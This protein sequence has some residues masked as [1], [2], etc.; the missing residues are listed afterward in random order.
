MTSKYSFH[1]SIPSAAIP[2]ERIAPA[3]P[4]AGSPAEQITVPLGQALVSGLGAAALVATVSWCFVTPDWREFGPFVLASGVGVFSA[5]WGVLMSD[6]RGLLRVS[7]NWRETTPATAPRPQDRLILVKGG[8]RGAPPDVEIPPADPQAGPAF[9]EPFMLQ[10]L[11]STALADLERRWPRPAVQS[12]RDALIAAGLAR[13]L[14]KG[15]RAGWELTERGRAVAARCRTSP[16]A[17]RE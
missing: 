2:G 11:T 5:V 12:A 3:S 6:S 13:W 1:E 7:E 17:V 14:G 4:T 10:C 9:F 8:D 15:K 16:G